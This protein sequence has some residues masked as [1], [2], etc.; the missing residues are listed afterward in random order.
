MNE[1]YKQDFIQAGKMAH[2][3]RAFGKALI[4]AGASYN[5]VITKIKEKIFSLGAIPAFPPQI[6]LNNVAAHFLPQPDEDII[7][8]QEVIKLDVGICYQGA[9]GDCAVTVDLSGKYQALI[10]AVE[11]A[12]LSAEQSI[13]VGL[14]IKEIGRIIEE[15]ISSYGFKSVKNLAGHGLGIYKVHTAPLIPNYCDN[16]TAIVKPGMT[17]A[18][19]PFAT[20]GKGFIY[21]AGS[22]AIFSFV[23]ARPIPLS[24]PRSLIAKIKSFSGLPFCMHDLIE[25]ELE[26]SEIRRHMA[27]LLKAGSVVGYAPLV[28][29]GQGIVAQAENSVLV[30]KMG[31]VFITTR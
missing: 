31:K 4:K 30:D 7:F 9:I 28:E 15:K 17:F 1:K 24:V 8:S 5:E 10:D 2:Q 12:L 26:L 11:S 19:E 13:Q 3:V 18:I 20:D 25:A 6:A 16:S 27:E 22:P 14:P 29:E 23:R 21:E